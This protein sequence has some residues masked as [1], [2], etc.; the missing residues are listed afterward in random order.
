MISIAES[1]DLKGGTGNTPTSGIG[2]CG[3]AREKGCD[4]SDGRKA[5]KRWAELG[6]LRTWMLSWMI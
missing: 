5:T 4:L 6:E 2:K 3:V 1:G